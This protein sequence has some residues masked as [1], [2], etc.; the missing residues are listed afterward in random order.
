MNKYLALI[1]AVLYG[2]ELDA[3]TLKPAPRLVVNI[4]IDQLRTDYL[5]HFAPLYGNDGFRKLLEEGCVYESP[6][7]PF[8]PVDRASAIAS[9]ATGTTPRYNGIAGMK[10]L[11]RNTLRPVH[12]TDD[13]KYVA[14]PSRM[15]TSTIGD[16]LKIS[17]Q[18]ASAVY[19]IAFDE[20]AAILSA[21]HAADGAFWFTSD[22]HQWTTSAYYGD[23]TVKWIKAYSKENSQNTENESIVQ[24]AKNCITTFVMG[25]DNT[26]DLLSLTL[27]AKPTSTDASGRNNSTSSTLT[28]WQTEMLQV[29]VGLDRQLATLIANVE[30]AVGRENVLFVLSGT[31]YTEETPTDYA[32]YRVPTGTFH[33]DRTANLLNMYLVA[34]YGQGRYVEACAGNQ[35]YLN[36]K[37]I[38]DR[39]ITLNEVIS[40][41]KDFLVQNTGVNNVSESPY[42]PAISGDLIVDVT[43]GWLLVNDETGEQY[44]SRAAFVPF[45][46]ILYGAGT[47]SRRV[48]Q[49]VSVCQIAPTIARA[50][51]IRAPNACSEAPLP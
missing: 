31:G 38:E 2:A 12:C 48:T 13:A 17:T 28:D 11:D 16:E 5:E 22:N 1:I 41:A 30:Q 3:Q 34:V 7:F 39:H 29:Y 46:L 19:S 45:P 4:A 42:N 50:I 25:R 27:S 37:L 14:S 15:T 6:S 43:P 36:R 24:L 9:I 26:P 33:I 23:A 32:H 49:P 51:R 8:S 40:R 10:W 35:I 18:G 20:A 47:S 21:G 44:T